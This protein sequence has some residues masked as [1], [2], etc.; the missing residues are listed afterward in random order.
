MGGVLR[1]EEKCDVIKIQICEIMG[2]DGIFRKNKMKKVPLPK[3]SLLVHL[4][5]EI[6]APLCSEKFG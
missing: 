5:G 3:I 4:G 2:L 6:F 1:R